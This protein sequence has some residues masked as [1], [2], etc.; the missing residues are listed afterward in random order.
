M[1][2]INVEVQNFSIRTTFLVYNFPAT[3]LEC[4]KHV[5]L[6]LLSARPNNTLSRFTFP[7]VVQTGCQ[8][9]KHALA[10]GQSD[11]SGVDLYVEINA[12][13]MKGS[14]IPALQLRF[15]YGFG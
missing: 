9:Q 2:Y 1:P 10:Y 5:D 15:Q 4:I 7:Y 11:V 12:L 14:S 13:R 6:S 3:F 8:L